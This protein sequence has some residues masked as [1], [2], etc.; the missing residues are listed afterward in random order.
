MDNNYKI[1]EVHD[2]ENWEIVRQFGYRIHKDGS[3]THIAKMSDNYLQQAIV[4]TQAHE[5]IDSL[6]LL[7]RE[8]KFREKWKINVNEQGELI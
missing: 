6:S 3:I 7:I 2:H 5:Q 1:I 4:Y 8:E